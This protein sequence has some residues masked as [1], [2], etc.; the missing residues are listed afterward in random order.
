MTELG[1]LGYYDIVFPKLGL[2]F[3]VKSEAFSIFGYSITWYGLIITFGLLLAMIYGFRQMRRVGIDPDRA[4][5]A[6]IAGIIGGII[7]ARTYFVI[8]HWDNYAGDW[9]SILNIRGGGLAIYGGIIG[10]I[11]VG[12]IVAKIRKVRLLPLLDVA[13]VSFLI[14]QGIGRW[15]NFTNHEAFGTNTDSLFGMSSG[16]IQEWIINHTAYA[17]NTLYAHGINLSENYPV[18][19]CFLYESVWCLL[20]FVILAII[21]KKKRLFDGQMCL[22]YI[23][24]YGTG[25][26]F[27][28]GLR[29]D[30]LYLGSVR[31]SQALALISAVTALILLIV[32]TAKVKRMGSDYHFYYETAESRQLLAE[33]DAKYKASEK[34][35]KGDVELDASDRILD[36]EES[37]D[38]SD[39]PVDEAEPDTETE[40]QETTQ[41]DE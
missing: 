26:F 1:N 31:V 30:S 32:F 14:G 9:K 23:L 10:A 18:H 19:P 2:E 34:K 13:C 36:A 21:F 24:W 27:I 39:A 25:R 12:G 11:L 8:F 37:A 6:V 4:I 7:G 22:M 15:G 40:T 20:G 38:A 29:T 41:E 33:S 3:T 16:K 5:D 28:E 35:R 17:E